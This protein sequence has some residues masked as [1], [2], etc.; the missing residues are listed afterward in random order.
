MLAVGR[1]VR[2]VKTIGDKVIS[3]TRFY[4]TFDYFG[5]ERQVGDR[6]VVGKLVF[7]WSTFFEK[8]VDDRF[9]EKRME[10]TWGDWLIDDVG[11]GRSKES[12]NLKKP[13][14]NRIRVR[15]FVRTVEEN[16][17]YFR[18]R[19]WRERREIGRFSWRRGWLLGWPW[20]TFNCYKCEFSRNFARFHSFGS[21]LQ[22]NE[23]R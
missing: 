8:W 7:V 5:Y 21:Q 19:C 2:I 9:F 6:T 15:L 4:N 23:W 11:Y 22:L 16:L 3:K 17:R 14:R 13:G 12:A 18:F 1:L 10:M 20:M